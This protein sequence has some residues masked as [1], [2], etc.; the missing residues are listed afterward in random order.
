MMWGILLRSDLLLALRL[1][2]APLR[3][4]LLRL[5]R[6]IMVRPLDSGDGG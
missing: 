4:D 6:S 1:A 5:M 2:L 3:P